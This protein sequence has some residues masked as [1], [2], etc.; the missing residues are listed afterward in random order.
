MPSIAQVHPHPL[1]GSKKRRWDEEGD[2]GGVGGLR[3]SG[4]AVYRLTAVEQQRSKR[5]RAGLESGISWDVNDGHHDHQLDSLNNHTHNNNNDDNSNPNGGSQ[6]ESCTSHPSAGTK[7]RSQVLPCHVC[8]RKPRVRQDI[9]SY[10]DCGICAERTCA[11]CLRECAGDSLRLDGRLSP[12]F[13]ED[14]GGE[15]GEDRG[16]MDGRAGDASFEMTDVGEE[17]WAKST[18]TLEGGRSGGGEEARL[19][20]WGHVGRVCSRCCV[21]RGVDG[22]VCCVGCLKR[23]G[24]S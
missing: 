2:V 9:D 12:N 3:A 6:K 19:Q 16:M 4:M 17:G 13:G 20:G 21:E 11:V 5:R 18:G 1:C 8:F 10:A 15:R 24:R 7:P 23:E 14:C 22:E